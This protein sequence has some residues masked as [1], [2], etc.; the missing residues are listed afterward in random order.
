MLSIRDRRVRIAVVIVLLLVIGVAGYQVGLS[1][2]GSWHYNAAVEALD[3]CD[4][5]A[6]ANHLD[7]CLW[8]RPSDPEI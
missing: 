2:W 1:V 4:F 6:A 7:K 8:V 3:R 5:K